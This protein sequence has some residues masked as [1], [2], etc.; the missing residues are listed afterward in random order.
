MM[1]KR[2]K[3]LLLFSFLLLGSQFLF[4]CQPPRQGDAGDEIKSRGEN[5]LRIFTK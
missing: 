2:T 1:K 4:S 5:G 3:L